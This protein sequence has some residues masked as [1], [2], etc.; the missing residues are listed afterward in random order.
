MKLYITTEGRAG[1]SLLYQHLK[2]LGVENVEKL[3]WGRLR[4]RDMDARALLPA[5]FIH[6]MRHDK[7]QQAVSRIKH[8]L[9]NQEHVRSDEQMTEYLDREEV[10]REVPLPKSDILDRITLNARGDKA[11]ELF[12][13]RHNIA[14]LTLY[15]EDLISNRELVLGQI[16]NWL[17][18]EMDF[19]KLSDELQSTHTDLN[20][21]WSGEILKASM[22]YLG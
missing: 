6:I 4:E 21:Q 19:S 1:S 5:R 7:V 13:E 9:H 11:W 22:Q 12:F 18:V 15:F 3:S 2:Q 8:L 17:G 20:D 16:C 10:F 14:A